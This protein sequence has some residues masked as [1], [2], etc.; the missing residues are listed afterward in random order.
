MRPDWL[1]SSSVF[2]AAVAAPTRGEAT[3]SSTVAI[4]PGIGSDGWTF[5]TEATAQVFGVNA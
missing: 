3:A 5:P 2:E 1:L 4:C